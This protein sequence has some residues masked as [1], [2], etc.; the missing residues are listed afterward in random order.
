MCSCWRASSTREAITHALGIGF[1]AAAISAA[2]AAPIVKHLLPDRR[3]TKPATARPQLAEATA[4]ICENA[5]Y[6]GSARLDL[7]PDAVR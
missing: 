4:L 1:L 3:T 5:G 7:P 6:R 2:L